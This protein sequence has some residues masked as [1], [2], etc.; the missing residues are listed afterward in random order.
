MIVLVDEKTKQVSFEDKPPYQDE[1]L[2]FLDFS[3][4]QYP[5]TCCLCLES[6]SDKSSQPN[7]NNPDPI[8]SWGRCCDECDRKE[9]IPERISRVLKGEYPYREV[10]PFQN[11]EDE[12]L[13]QEWYGWGPNGEVIS[14]GEIHSEMFVHGRS[15]GHKTQDPSVREKYVHYIK[16][17]V[18]LMNNRRVFGGRKKSRKNKSKDPWILN[19][20]HYFSGWGIFGGRYSRV[21][22][23]LSIF[24]FHPQYRTRGKDGSVCGFGGV[25]IV[26]PKTGFTLP[27]EVGIEGE[28]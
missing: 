18:D 15:Q 10:Q 1:L 28:K 14:D 11:K 7:G 19:N 25:G 26:P 27:L 21:E 12:P 9:V 20:R 5:Q 24:S 17:M 8:T 2:S 23:R 6:L 13:N 4:G 16:G 3:D 22:N